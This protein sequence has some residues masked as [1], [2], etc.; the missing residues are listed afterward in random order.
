[1]LPNS[2][3]GFPLAG[4]GVFQLQEMLTQ[5]KPALPVTAAVVTR[6]Y[7]QRAFALACPACTAAAIVGTNARAR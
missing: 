2:D 5:A 3:K 1:M 7:K 6:E 4:V